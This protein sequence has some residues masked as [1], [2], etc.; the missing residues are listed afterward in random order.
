VGALIA[1]LALFGLP[2]ALGARA[3]RSEGPGYVF[4]AAFAGLVLSFIGLGL[5]YADR[6]SRRRARL[7]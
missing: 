5:V 7:R 2:A 1:L 3:G 4:A 6:R